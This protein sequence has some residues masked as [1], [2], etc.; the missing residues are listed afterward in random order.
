MNDNSSYRYRVFKD[1]ITQCLNSDEELD[2]KEMVIELGV[3]S[4]IIKA[5]KGEFNIENSVKDLFD[6][7]S[8][9]EEV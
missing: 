8:P 5:L 3:I 1:G 4:E 9:E 2:L 7:I 6:A